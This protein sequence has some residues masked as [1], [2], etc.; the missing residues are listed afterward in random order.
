MT[1][2]SFVVDFIFG[3][4]NYTVPLQIDL[5][6]RFDENLLI[7]SYDATLR[8][9]PQLFKTVKPIL[10]QQIAIELN[11]TTTTNVTEL[12]VK[13]AAIDVCTAHTTY[14]TGQDQQFES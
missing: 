8:R 2:S 12:V 14:C 11:D 9:L 6:F 13:R 4:V 5:L 10:A 3:S 7:T 1:Y